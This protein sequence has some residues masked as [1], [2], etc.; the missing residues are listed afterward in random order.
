[1]PVIVNYSHLAK[2]AEKNASTFYFKFG[3]NTS[4]CNKQVNG[5]PNYPIYI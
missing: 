2:Y 1:M 4:I 5:K 3:K